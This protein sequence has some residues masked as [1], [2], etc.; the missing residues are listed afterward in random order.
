MSVRVVK[1]QFE[2]IKRHMSPE[3]AEC[4]T[5]MVVGHLS[6]RFV[7]RGSETSICENRNG[8]LNFF[9]FSPHFIISQGRN[10]R[11]SPLLQQRF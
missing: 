7:C 8:R 5:L 4:L 6:I 11:Y 9:I 3:V 1:D 2:E 10:T